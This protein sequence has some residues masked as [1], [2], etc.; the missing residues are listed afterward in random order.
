MNKFLIIG[1]VGLVLIVVGSMWSKSVKEADPNVIST[2]GIH[3]HPEVEIYVKGEQV[4]IPNNTG[5]MGGHNPIHT[6]EDL[7]IIHL[8][9]DR[10]VTYDEIKLNMFFSS[11][12][13]DI[14]EL[15]ENLVMTVNGE[16][17]LELG[18]YIMQD[19][20]KIVLTYE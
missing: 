5:L 14:N 13:K 20:D 19:E 3:W 8:E 9:F 10:S 15:G 1:A 18:E 12:N 7:P 2:K 4:E 6:H 17:N 16:E 11:W